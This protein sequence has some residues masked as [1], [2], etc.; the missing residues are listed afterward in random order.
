[1]NLLQVFI[2]TAVDPRCAQGFSC[3]ET[4]YAWNECEWT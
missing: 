3:L 2:I 4:Q 1:M